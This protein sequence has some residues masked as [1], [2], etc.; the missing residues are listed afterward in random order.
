MIDKTL[1]ASVAAAALVA[2]LASGSA[3]QAQQTP[4]GALAA[5]TGFGAGDN[6]VEETV[7][8]IREEVEDDFERDITRFGN[9]G[10]ELGFRGSI[11]LRATATSGNS[12][13]TNI[14]LGAGLEYFD[15]LNGS[16]LSLA[17]TYFD[18]GDGAED[19]EENLYI[20]TDYTRELGR[21]IFGYARGVAIYDNAE[22]GDDDD[23]TGGSEYRSDVFAGVG[24]GYRVVNSDSL[25]WSVQAGPGYRW[26]EPFGDDDPT[27]PEVENE[28]AS[29]AAVSLTSN[30]LYQFSSTVFVTNDT[31]VI[32]SDA[33][34]SVLN[35]LAL[36]VAL[37]ESLSLRTSLLTE[38]QSD[39]GFDIGTGAEFDSTDNTLGVAVVYS[40]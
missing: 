18:D 22:P 5:G 7:E 12:E 17:Y 27:T 37:N 36:N 2:A 39:P 8:D 32:A 1:W 35:D 33:N 4:G 24:L 16:S 31:D 19:V 13:N 23:A 25:Q 14:G 9:E 29:E 30:L 34:T 10:R 28:R 26:Y 11:A 38:Y 21:D 15:G 3:A 20:S 40:F 6:V